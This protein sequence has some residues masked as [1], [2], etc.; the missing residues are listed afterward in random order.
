[1]V[2]TTRR[3]ASLLM[4][5]AA[6]SATAQVGRGF[7]GRAPIDTADRL[8]RG[9]VGFGGF[10]GQA[11]GPRPMLYGFALECTRCQATNRRGGFGAG[12]MAVWRYDE[13]PR[14]AAVAEG[15]PAA[16][17]GIRQGD[18]LLDI[19]G[20]SLITEAGSQAFS[21]L[22]AGDTATLTLERN[23]KSYSTTLVLGRAFGAK[24]GMG[25][26]PLRL[27]GQPHFSTRVGTTAI[28]IDS[29]VPVI[30]TTDSSGAT[31]LRVGST[32]IRLRPAKTP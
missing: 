13:F 25:R 30:S 9:A 28:D 24:G 26:G 12:P 22:V 29:D 32:T 17:A 23:G 21:A 19:G 1:M 20:A 3:L 27:D 5:L 10:A 18:L 6:T 16:R 11:G 7:R 4:A 31:T 8:N 2:L 14:V 15:G